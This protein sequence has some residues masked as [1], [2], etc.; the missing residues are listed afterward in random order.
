VGLFLSLHWNAMGL[1]SFRR[2]REQQAAEAAAATVVDTVAA[3]PPPP[4]PKT[5]RTLKSKA[6]LAG[7]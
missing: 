4:R 1:Y 5:P 3:P 7:N 6:N 2:L